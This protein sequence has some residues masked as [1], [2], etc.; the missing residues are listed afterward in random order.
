M[1]SN[2]DVLES[3]SLNNKKLCA[4]VANGDAAAA[5]ALYAQGARLMPPNMGIVESPD[6]ASYWQGAIDMGIVDATLT[7]DT[8]DVY[9]DTA[10]EVGAYVLFGPDRI[11]IDNGTYLVVWRNEDGTWKLFQDIF[12]TNVPVT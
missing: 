5:A 3:I 11:E 7:S 8:V 1:S 2:A 9:G 12:N 4:A 10:I 6:L